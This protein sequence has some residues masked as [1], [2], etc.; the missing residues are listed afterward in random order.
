MPMT[1][2]YVF[3]ADPF[4]NIL[5]PSYL[6]MPIGTNVSI[7]IQYAYGS[8]GYVNS[9][10]GFLFDLEVVPI[11]VENEPFSEFENMNSINEKYVYYYNFTVSTSD[12]ADYEFQGKIYYI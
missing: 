3:T 8:E 2:C 12:H 11:N 4:W 1:F 9:G 7:V 5:S 6:E 10:T